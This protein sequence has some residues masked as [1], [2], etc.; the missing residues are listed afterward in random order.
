MLFGLF[1]W[2]KK[3]LRRLLGVEREN[4]DLRD[5]VRALYALLY[6]LVHQPTSAIDLAA[7][8]T[9]KAFAHQ[10]AHLPEGLYLL[11]DQWFRNNVARILWE[12]EIQIKPEWFHGKDVL[13]AGCGNGRWAYGLSSLGANL[14]LVDQSAE[15]IEATRKALAGV[16]VKKEFY[17]TP[18]EE[19][20]VN[21]PARQYDLVFSWGVL[22]HCRSFE[23]AFREVVGRV[24]EGGLLY[25][26]LYGRES[27]D[28]EAEMELF[29]T[30]LRVAMMSPDERERFLLEKTG[31][32]PQLVHG[33]HDWYVPLIN[34]RYEFSEIKQALEHEGF[35]D[36]TRTI[37][38][39]ELFIRAVKGDHREEYAKWFLPAKEP[40]YWFRHHE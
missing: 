15:A 23:R 32:K 5:E 13:D 3:A 12:E 2:L 17:V 28:V 29:R 35:T 9:E 16:P 31:G 6:H 10:W 34:R 27:M 21:L 39:T 20:S 40:P 25:L 24:K 22:H 36:V 8:Q 1:R 37:K 33:F 11:S 26:Y 38:Y 19:L 30:R 18:L 14:T 7:V 4:N